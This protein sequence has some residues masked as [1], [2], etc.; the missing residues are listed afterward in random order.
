MQLVV[1]LIVDLDDVVDDEE[2][3]RDSEKS[4]GD[5]GELEQLLHPLQLGF[6]PVRLLRL[7]F[8]ALDYCCNP[9]DEIFKDPTL[10]MKFKCE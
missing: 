1:K 6:T 9:E 2:A 7:P 5:K 3:D 8:V 4:S 10:S